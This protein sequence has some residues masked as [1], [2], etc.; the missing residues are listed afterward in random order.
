MKTRA[1]LFH[2]VGRPLEVEE[3]DLDEPRPH[4]VVVRMSAVGICGTD[5]HI[6]NWDEWAAN[7]LAASVMY[8]RGEPEPAARKLEHA[9]AIVTDGRSRL[10]RAKLARL[11]LGAATPRAFFSADLGVA[12]PDPAPFL[13]ALGWLGCRP[14]EALF[15][16][17][18]PD[19]DIAGAAGVGMRTCLISGGRAYPDGPPRP[20]RTIARVIDL[21]AEVLR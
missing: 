6:Y 2:A 1:A 15:V 14:D 8:L 4:E 3:I 17:D 7:H 9:L 21:E 20:D 13:A 5:L 12:K 16:G 18:N 19:R 11:G 10:Q